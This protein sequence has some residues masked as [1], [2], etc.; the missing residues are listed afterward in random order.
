[1]EGM[2]RGI[3]LL[4][5]SILIIWTEDRKRGDGG[6]E[7]QESIRQVHCCHVSVKQTIQ[8]TVGVGSNPLFHFALASKLNK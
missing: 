2:W 5:G 1:M 6:K 8:D 7:T 3:G 4:I